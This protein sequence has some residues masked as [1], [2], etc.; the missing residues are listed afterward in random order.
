MQMTLLGVGAMNSPRYRP[1]G[2]AVR[3]AGHR[4]V[5]DGVDAG[6]GHVDAWLVCDERAELMPEIRRRSRELGVPAGAVEYCAAGVRLRPLPVEHTSHPTF[7]YLV[8]HREHRVVWA[9]EFW[10]FPDWAAGA[11]LVFADAAGWDR[12]IRFAGG[13]GGHAS[14]VDTA[15]RASRAGVRRLVFAHIGRPS[16]RAIDRGLT[17]PFGEWGAEGRTYAVVSGRFRADRP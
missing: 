5:L 3:W 11:D 1:A 8:E 17:P 9:P 6:G 16:I 10:R 12:P 2:L 7:G 4:V 15:R 13:V 14:T